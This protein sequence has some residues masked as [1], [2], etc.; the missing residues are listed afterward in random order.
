MKK[1]LVIED[2]TDVR[3]VVLDIL[4]AEN[5]DVI[6]A[7]NGRIGV[8]MATAERPDLILCDV[9]MPELDGYGVLAALRSSPVTAAIPFIFLTAKATRSDLRQGMDLGADDYLTKPFTRDEMLGAIGTRFKRQA[10]IEQK[11]QAQLDSL[12]HNISRS[13]PHELRTP[14]NGIISTSQFLL[15]EYADLELEEAQ[16]MLADINASGRRLHRLIQNFLL[17]AELELTAR[18]PEKLWAL[19]SLSLN[20]P[21]A[22]IE[23][24]A[25][26]LARGTGDTGRIMP[27]RAAD[28]TLGVQN[29]R[30][31]ISE[32]ALQKMTFELVDNALKFSQPGQPVT[33]TGEMKGDRYL[34]RVIDHGRGLSPD[35][36][37][38]V[39]AYQQFDRKLYEQQGSGLGLSIVMRLCEL[40][41]ADLSITSEPGQ[42]T[43]VQVSFGS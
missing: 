18:D 20:T 43:I 24:T 28:L 17:Y 40:Y 26:Q 33:V 35:Q 29:H 42:E 13:L 31:A 16:E 32:S 9:M 34:L 19:R 21:A 27:D 22:T 1:I 10:A 4:E 14:L 12:R 6:G 8:E 7:P 2:E 11:S 15:D 3:E 36:I 23:P 38:N 37:A 41:Q 25:Q 30:V 39:G 5:F